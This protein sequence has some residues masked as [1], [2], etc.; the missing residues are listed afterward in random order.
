[1]KRNLLILAIILFI[2]LI[3]NSCGDDDEQPEEDIAKDRSK[4]VSIFGGA[5]SVTIKGHLTNAQLTDA[6]NKIAGRLN[7]AF[8]S[9]GGDVNAENTYKDIFARG[10]TYIVEVTPN[11]YTKFKTI[12]DGKTI[13]IV[14]STVDTISV[15][16]AIGSIY[17]NG[18]YVGQLQ[19][20]CDAK[21]TVRMAMGKVPAVKTI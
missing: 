21:N 18:S 3:V 6:S 1:M 19:K 5:S 9:F 4:T 13:Y 10:V 14:L 7:T 16:D 8:N 11:G 15:I 20:F 12:G 2:G 17:N